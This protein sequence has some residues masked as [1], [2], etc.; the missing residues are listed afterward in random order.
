MLIEYRDIY[1]NL[2]RLGENVRTSLSGF[3]DDSGIPIFA[4][5]SRIKSEA[6]VADKM[7]RKEYGGDLSK[8]EDLCGVRVICYYQE[9]IDKICG[10]VDAEFSIVTKEDKRTQL[11]NDQFGY[12][13]CHY[14]VTLKDTW[15]EHPLCRGLGGLKVE[16]QIRTMLMHTWSAISHKL[17]YK[18]ETDVP[19]QFLRALNRLSALIELADEQFDAIK[20]VKYLY[21]DNLVKGGD[22]QLALAALNSDSLLAIQQRFFKGRNCV[23][24]QFTDLLDEIRFAGYGVAE[25]VHHIRECL[26]IMDE[27]ESEEAES[28]DRSLPMWNFTGAIRTVLDLT[29]DKYFQ[30]R[31]DSI[32]AD[33]VA[34]R[35]KFRER[36]GYA[37]F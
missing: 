21:K 16:I 7:I 27:M 22:D 25:L 29:S 30:R 18:R 28:S 20:N 14:V 26:P 23:S 33:I 9:D 8:L 31:A 10:V 12:T 3:L 15:L 34:S 32:P 35:N 13:S 2:L 36:L 1:P 5:E 6:S 37:Q 24:D 17:L 4:I 19:P 11:E